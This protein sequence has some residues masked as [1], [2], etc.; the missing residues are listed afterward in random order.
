MGHLRHLIPGSA[1][2]GPG[3]VDLRIEGGCDP[4]VR[5]LAQVRRNRLNLDLES[6]QVCDQAGLSWVQ[7]RR[8]GG[9]TR[10]PDLV[11]LEESQR[12]RKDLLA[13]PLGALAI[14]S[15]QGVRIPR[16]QSTTDD[17]ACQR[18]G[19]IRVITGHRNQDAHC[20]AR[21][22]AARH[23]FVENRLPKD[24]DQT[25]AG[26]HPSSRASEHR[27][28]LDQAQTVPFVEFAD[29]QGLVDCARTG[30]RHTNPNPHQRLLDRKIDHL[31]IDHVA[32][33]A[34]QGSHPSVTIH[35]D[36]GVAWLVTDHADRKLLADRVQ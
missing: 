25:Q 12:V 6:L 24:A 17:R 15:I 32:A 22:D 9:L 21:R 10:A 11:D 34:A 36:P 2:C 23:D 7:C 27:S 14:V 4:A 13:H 31:R 18:Q 33:Q 19:V 28:Q 16:C 30:A 29:Q 5:D 1:Q 20:S 3:Q 8:P 26:T 35:H